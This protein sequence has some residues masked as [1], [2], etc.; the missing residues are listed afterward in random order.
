MNT[1]LVLPLFAPGTEV[2]VRGF[3]QLEPKRVIGVLT[4]EALEAAFIAA[5]QQPTITSFPHYEVVDVPY[6]VPQI[7]LSS[8]PLKF[9]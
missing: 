2:Y 8:N 5:G 6:P 3:N 9:K 1:S 7:R 4:P